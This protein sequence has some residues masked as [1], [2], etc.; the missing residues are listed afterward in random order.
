VASNRLD[1]GSKADADVTGVATS[2]S[3]TTV[4]GDLVSVTGRSRRVSESSA[5]HPRVRKS[6]GVRV[7]AILAVAA[8]GD[9]VA[10]DD[11][12]GGALTVDDRTRTAFTH[13]AP[14]LGVDDLGRHHAGAGQFDFDWNLPILGPLYNNTG[15]IECH[16]GNGRGLSLIGPAASSDSQGM[17]LPRSQSLIRVSL[18]TGMPVVPGGDVPVPGFG[19]QLRDHAII[20]S[21]QVD[22]ALAWVT[23]DEMFGDGDVVTLRA[24][25]LDVRL[26]DGSTFRGDALQSYR[27]APAVFG[28]GLLEAVPAETIRAL[29]DPDDRD[30]D[31]IRGHANEVW[32]PKAQ[33]M[34]LGRFGAKANVPTI[35]AQVA[36]AFANDIGVTNPLFPDA[37]GATEIGGDALDNTQFFVAT[38]GVPAPTPAGAGR[39]RFDDFQCATCHVPTLET[40]G[41]HPIELLRN[42]TI[43]PYTDLLLHDLGDGLA[44]HRPDFA[45]SGQEWRTAPLW[46]LGVVQVVSPGAGF[47][48]DGRART[49]EEA[50]LWHGGEA[51]AAREAYRTATRADR[52]AVLQFLESL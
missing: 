46:G 35:E 27:Q 3:V 1:G 7:I 5:T 12:A 17:I 50:I 32:D 52:L 11:R 36:G 26:P 31:G 4:G 22:V 19:L 20:G 8:C 38:L 34:A 37:T 39:A 28:L 42:Q 16:G 23:H 10:I 41:D 14:G 45:A 25:A 51:A 6:R 18:A 48:H 40:G 24:P 15:C 43:H 9:N 2:S 13:P 21:Q 33:A 30:G 29:A 49:I 44:D 47:L